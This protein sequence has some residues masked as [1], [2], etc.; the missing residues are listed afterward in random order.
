[1]VRSSSVP[2][3]KMNQ[4]L[5]LLT[6]IRKDL[7]SNLG[8]VTEIFACLSSVPYANTGVLSQ[9]VDVSFLPDRFQFIIHPSFYH[10]TLYN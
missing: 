1:M 6:F 7:G 3:S 2:P 8:Q 4:A 10:S 9:S 5:R